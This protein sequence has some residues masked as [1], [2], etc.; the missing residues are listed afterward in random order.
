MISAMSSEQLTTS[1][2][3]GLQVLDMDMHKTKRPIGIMRRAFGLPSP[4]AAA[5]MAAI[6]TVIRRREATKTVEPIGPHQ[7]LD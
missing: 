7:A 5:A 4:G 6:R 1:Q 3:G 2:S